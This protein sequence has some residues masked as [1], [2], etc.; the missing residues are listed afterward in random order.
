[1][2]KV[3]LDDQKLNKELYSNYN[4]VWGKVH[5]LLTTSPLF[6]AEPGGPTGPLEP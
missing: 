6:P 5:K 3:Y 2:Q 1:M 4:T